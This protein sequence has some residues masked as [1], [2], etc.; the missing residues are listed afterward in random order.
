L[1][2]DVD[3]AN[4]ATG[5]LVQYA[6]T[7]EHCQLICEDMLFDTAVGLEWR[8]SPRRLCVFDDDDDDDDMRTVNVKVKVKCA[9]LLLE[10]RRSAHL[11]S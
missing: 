4:R 6:W 2:G 1:T 7:V 5:G 11:P 9:I 3:P 8:N 10:R